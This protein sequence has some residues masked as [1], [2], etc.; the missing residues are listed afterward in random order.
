[1]PSLLPQVSAVDAVEYVLPLLTDLAMEADDGMKEALSTELVPI[2]WWFSSNCRLTDDETADPTDVLTPLL[3]QAL[4][5][6]LR[7]LLLSLSAPVAT[8]ARSAIVEIIRRVRD[9]DAQA[10]NVHSELF[11]VDERLL[12]EQEIL[13]QVVSGIGGLDIPDGGWIG[14]V[15]EEA[16]V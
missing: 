14:T 11:E 2:V 4:T 3:V 13:Q 10:A 12:L 8:A 16:Q 7:A 9:A 5:P 15:D 1:M 6:I